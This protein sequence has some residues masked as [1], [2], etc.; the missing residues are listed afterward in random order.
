MWGWGQQLGASGAGITSGFGRPAWGGA[1]PRELSS[2]RRQG[3]GWCG[4]RQ[5]TESTLKARK[6]PPAAS[7]EHHG[8]CLFCEALGVLQRAS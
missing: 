3:A 8:L 7:A 2:L 4:V 6:K 5:V 1:V